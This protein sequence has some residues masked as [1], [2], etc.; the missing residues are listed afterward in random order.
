MITIGVICGSEEDEED[1]YWAGSAAD[2]NGN[3]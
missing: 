1:E 3:R 2:S